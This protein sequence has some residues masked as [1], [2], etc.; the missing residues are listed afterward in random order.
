M[1]RQF[2]EAEAPLRF[3]L[4][5]DRVPVAFAALVATFILA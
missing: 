4:E 1:A 3:A 5:I 2:K